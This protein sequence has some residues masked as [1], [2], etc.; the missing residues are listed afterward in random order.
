[1]IVPLCFGLLIWVCF[2]ELL[3][4]AP[5]FCIA[6][7]VAWLLVVVTGKTLNLWDMGSLFLAYWYGAPWYTGTSE[8]RLPSP[9]LVGL[10]VVACLFHYCL[11]LGCLSWLGLQTI[12]VESSWA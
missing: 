5:P 9:F 10:L 11:V 4:F 7:S 8:V 6:T 2:A 12:R 1:M 3:G